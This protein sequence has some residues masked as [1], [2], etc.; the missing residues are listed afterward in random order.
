MALVLPMKPVPASRVDPAIL[1]IYGAKKVGKTKLLTQLP[2]CCI[3][4]GEKGTE[5]LDCLK[6]SFNNI[7]QLQEIIAAIRLEGQRRLNANKEAKTLKLP[8][9]YP[10]DDVYPYRYLA[11]DTV[12]EL[13]ECI[14]PWGTANYKATDK[15]KSFTG[16]SMLELEYGLGYFFLREGVKNFIKDLVVLCKSLII[17]SHLDEK[18]TDKG[19]MNVT[20][21]DI[22]LS[23]KLSGIVCAMAS[24]IG[25]IS[26]KPS[27]I[28]GKIDPIT[29]SFRTTEGITMG[30]R[31]KHLAGQTFEFDWKR[32]FITDPVLNPD[33]KKPV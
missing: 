8:E 15:G 3:I 21:Q 6:M 18:V 1:I 27:N 2:N 7:Y 22:S 11:L 16:S 4:D 9:P 13:Q 17:I 32:I 28:E 24:A 33:Y 14:V 30:A 20:V 12:D 10:G 26:R 29:I 25:Y 31:T 19:G 5:E 23:G